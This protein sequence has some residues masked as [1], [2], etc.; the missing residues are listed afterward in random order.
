MLFLFFR[1]LRFF[2]GISLTR[3]HYR[4]FYVYIY[5]HIHIIDKG[6]LRS[7]YVYT[8]K[9]ILLIRA[10]YDIQR[11]WEHFMCRDTYTHMHVS[12]IHILYTHILR[13]FKET[14]HPDINLFFFLSSKQNY[15]VPVQ[16]F[17]LAFVIRLLLIRPLPFLGILQLIFRSLLTSDD[18][19]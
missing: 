16:F 12:P 8:Y 11:R 2:H 13:T 9:Y 6:T 1:F 10:H 7:F 5:I 15:H 14:W 18:N 4:R 17:A 3:V 19:N